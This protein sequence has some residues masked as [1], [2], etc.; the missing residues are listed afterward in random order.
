[1]SAGA[2]EV[3]GA[4]TG[5]VVGKA[6]GTAGSAAAGRPTDAAAGPA[7]TCPGPPSDVCQA[8]ALARRLGLDRIDAQWLLAHLLQTPRT[9]LISHG[10][11]PLAEPVAQ[12]FADA[13][14]RC[15]DGEPLAYLLGEQEFHGLRLQVTPD[16][17]VPRPD[18][19]TLVDWALALLSAWLPARLPALSPIPVPTLAPVPRGRQ[20]QV[21]DLG[22]G[23]GAIALAVAHR[24][25]GAHVSATDI[26]RAALTVAQRNAVRLGLV[27]EWSLGDWWQALA[28]G[29]SIRQFDLA[30]CNPPYIAGDDPH[31]P[32]L[33]HEPLAALTPGG[34]GLGA[35]Q[36]VICGAPA[37]LVP[38]GWLLLE[39]GWDQAPAVTSALRAAG[40]ESI[41]TRHDIAGRPRCSG[42]CL[43]LARA[44]TPAPA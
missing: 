33:Q 35:L 19:E 29:D 13:C 8:L 30:L 15:A 5:A 21:L 25:P 36:A 12:A 22:T 42:G 11:A 44:W 32:A 16:V 17:L 38:G 6:V 7:Q 10:D 18:T 1:M 24:H 23:S 39:H 43:P 40:F 26:S 3:A 2:G 14:R 28:A 31:L 9:W 34:D 27:I 20:P 41:S 37:H 4:A